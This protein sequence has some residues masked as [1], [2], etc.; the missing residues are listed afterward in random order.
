M[1][2]QY[3]GSS[4]Y[5]SSHKRRRV[6]PANRVR[7]PSVSSAVLGDRIPTQLTE[8]WKFRSSWGRLRRRKKRRT[9][10]GGLV[11]W[12]GGLPPHGS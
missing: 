5:P 6:D 12:I 11:G 9:T 10:R 2:V 1:R 4:P 3:Q 7:G 8:V